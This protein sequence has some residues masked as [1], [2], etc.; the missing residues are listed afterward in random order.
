MNTMLSTDRKRWS[1]EAACTPYPK[2]FGSD[3]TKST[4]KAA[5]GICAMCPVKDL[6]FEWALANEAEGVFG[7]TTTS[8]RKDLGK[9]RLLSAQ[10]ACP[11][12]P[13]L[14]DY[15]KDPEPQPVVTQ[16]PKKVSIPG[17]QGVYTETQAPTHVGQPARVSSKKKV[18]PT[19]QSLMASLDQL[20]LE[21]PAFS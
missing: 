10:L 4:I 17:T 21:L 16:K 14:L 8:E 5:K 12:E 18:Q 9:D 1:Q 20:L 15:V 13:K 11:P 19:H 3:L 2:L 6:C 7:G